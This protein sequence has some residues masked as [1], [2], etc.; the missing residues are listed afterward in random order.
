MLFSGDVEELMNDT[1]IMYIPHES[2]LLDD[3][4]LPQIQLEMQHLHHPPDES[5]D[6]DMFC[7]QVSNIPVDFGINQHNDQHSE[8]D[9]QINVSAYDIHSNLRNQQKVAIIAST[10][11]ESMHAT[12]TYS[13]SH[14][15]QEVAIIDPTTTESK[16]ENEDIIDLTCDQDEVT[17]IEPPISESRQGDAC[18]IDL[19]VESMRFQPLSMHRETSDKQFRLLDQ[20]VDISFIQ[21]YIN[22]G[23]YEGFLIRDFS[24]ALRKIVCWEWFTPDQK[25]HNVMT[26]TVTYRDS[27]MLPLSIK[28]DMIL[29][30][31]H[32]LFVVKPKVDAIKIKLCN[33]RNDR[34][35]DQIFAA[36][37]QHRQSQYKGKDILFHRI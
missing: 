8:H 7:H 16:Q 34:K 1:S 24:V 18:M 2:S 29:D 17:I 22:L 11:S 28:K 3:F 26:I 35:S 19:R 33:I 21:R 31:I 10:T 9:R 32:K 13:N 27:S 25:Y 6:I 4:V 14:N 5:L 15:Q 23:Y 12:D 37:K 30:G 36:I 20:S